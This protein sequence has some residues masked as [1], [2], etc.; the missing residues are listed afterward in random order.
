MQVHIIIATWFGCGNASK[1]P[2]TVASL[3]TILLAPAIVFNNLIGILLLALVLIIGLLAIPKYL[4]DYP[5][6]IDPK[7]IVI[8]EVIGQLIAFITTIIFF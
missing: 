5:D 7:E 1:A 3:A 6:V 8:D 4:L 2:G